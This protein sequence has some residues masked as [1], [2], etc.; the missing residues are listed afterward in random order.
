M[1][2][3]NPRHQF[4]PSDLRRIILDM[5]FRSQCVHV[6][7]AFSLVEVFAALYSKWLN[8]NPKDPVDPARDYLVLSKGHGVMALYA[9]F[10]KIG[11]MTDEDSNNYLKDGTRLFGLAE[12]PIPGIEAS[13]GSLGHGL[14]IATGIAFGLKRKKSKQ[15]VICI[16]GDGEMNEGPMWEA[17]LFAAHHKLDNLTVIVDANE[18]QAMGRT[19]DILS[20]EPFSAKLQSFGMNVRECNGNA[21][22]Q[23]HGAL[24][25]LDETQGNGKPKA[26][27]ARTKKGHGISFMSGDNRWHYTR[28]DQDTLDKC[29]KELAV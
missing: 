23:V 14:P 22:E 19:E 13:A 16:V 7:C 2:E 24:T 5:A 6:P 3:A 10:K 18:Y 21:L 26:L 9:C 28:I 17:L 20:L 25:E 8:Y 27:I 12:Y 4:E 11:W 1:H 29:L 15:K